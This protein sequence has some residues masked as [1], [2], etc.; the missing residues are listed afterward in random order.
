MMLYMFGLIYLINPYLF[1]V[2]NDK[3][4]GLLFIAVFF[5]SLLLP[6][7][8]IIMMRL[9]G[10]SATLEMEKP[11]ERIG[12][13]II[14]GVCYIWL[15]LNIKDNSMIPLAF[16]MFVLGATISLFLAF[17]I[18]NFEKISLHAVGV[19]GFMMAYFIIA[20]LYGQGSLV[21]E[22]SSTQKLVINLVW[23]AAI[24]IFLTGLVCTARTYLG[25]HSLQQIFGGLIVGVLGQVIAMR[26]IF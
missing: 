16:N 1:Q 5:T 18:N 11:T 20:S 21:I 2:N 8:G 12:P 26:I 10:F 14:T 23:L 4:L 25:A 3:T 6:A 13:L 22:I 19:A 24:I 9:L 15:F 17:F 7:V